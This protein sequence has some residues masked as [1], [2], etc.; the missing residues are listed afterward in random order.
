[1]EELFFGDT[2]EEPTVDS[3]GY[4]MDD[5][6]AEELLGKIAWAQDEIQKWQKFYAGQ[7]EKASDRY[8]RMI[9]HWQARLHEYFETV[10]HRKTKSGIE[11]YALPGA[12][13]VLTAPG[14][15][16]IRNDEQLLAWCESEHPEYIKTKKTPD[17]AAIKKAIGKDGLIPDGVEP[18]EKEAE[19]KISF[20]KKEE[21]NG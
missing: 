2:Y 6:Q 7:M 19:F 15:E 4:V 9:E 14:V 12:E 1:M 3:Y 21:S 18:V 13:L 5:M 20:N 11:K 16:Y 10:P 8:N 17:W